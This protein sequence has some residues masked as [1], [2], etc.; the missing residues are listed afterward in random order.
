MVGVLVG[1]GVVRECCGLCG[2]YAWV[3]GWSMGG[4]ERGDGAKS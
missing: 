1:G 4:V 2:M 3:W